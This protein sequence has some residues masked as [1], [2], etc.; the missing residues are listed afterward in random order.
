MP[1]PLKTTVTFSEK[2]SLHPEQLLTLF[3]QAP[4]AKGR[5]LSDA[6]EMLR[7]TDVALCAWDGERLYVAGMRDVLVCLNGTDGTVVWRRDFVSELKTPLPAFGFVSSPL[8]D[9][10]HLYTQAG[11]SVARLDKRTGAI[12]W[13]AMTDEGG[14]NGSAF[15]SPVMAT[16]AGKRQLVVHTRT[17]LAGLDPEEES[18]IV[19]LRLVAE[20]ICEGA[21]PAPLLAAFKHP[22]AAGG[23]ETVAFR[24]QARAL[25]LALLRG[26]RPGDSLIE[27]IGRAHV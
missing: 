16:L 13:R 3:Q 11:A 12:Q 23:S 26:P 19:F 9:G 15:S 10:D 17:T 18:P 27:Q 4:W 5:T 25:E 21:A 20:L 14:M 7:H 6:R 2:K 8:V 22:L 24:T 1:P